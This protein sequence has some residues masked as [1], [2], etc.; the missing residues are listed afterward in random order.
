MSAIRHLLLIT[1][2]LSLVAGAGFAQERK[3]EAPTQ[4]DIAL[5]NYLFFRLRTPAAGYTVAARDT[6]INQRIVEIFEAGEPGPVTIC[7][8]RGKPT[9]YVNGVKLVTVYPRDAEAAGN[10]ICT[11][12]LARAWASRI[13]AGLRKVWPGCRFPSAATAAAAA[14]AEGAAAPEVPVATSGK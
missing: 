2:A 5:D 14:P 4:A 6:L 13:E 12:Q 9:I 3:Y 7:D 1:V 10:G 8:V 11:Q